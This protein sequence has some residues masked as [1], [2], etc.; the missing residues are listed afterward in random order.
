MKYALSTEE[1]EHGDLSS[2]ELLNLLIRQVRT[3]DRVFSSSYLYYNT[4]WKEEEE[5]EKEEIGVC[6]FIVILIV[7]FRFSM[8]MIKSSCP[9]LFDLMMMMV[10]V[11]LCINLIHCRPSDAFGR[12]LLKE[13][14]LRDHSLPVYEHP[15]RIYL[16]NHEDDLLTFIR[17][18][19]KTYPNRRSSFHAMRGK[20]WSLF[21]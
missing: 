6:L 19:L 14:L 11:L 15:T 1:I 17:E 7:S 4:R 18:A 8:A 9:H 5:E 13:R 10:L 20:R 2:V 12:T 16:S 3:V 21:F